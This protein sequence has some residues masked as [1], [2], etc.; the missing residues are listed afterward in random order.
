LRLLVVNH[1]PVF[2]PNNGGKLRIVSLVE[3][4]SR[5]FDV[6]LLCPLG[7]REVLR[8]DSATRTTQLTG[9]G[10][11]L[12]V[13]ESPFKPALLGPLYL[14]GYN[15]VDALSSNRVSDFS[16]FASRVRRELVGSTVVL[17]E[18]PF[19]SRLIRRSLTPR[20]RKKVIYDAIDVEF[21]SASF[22][23]PRNPVG[24]MLLSRVAALERTAC[25][26]SD[27][28]F[29]TTD[30]DKAL[31]ERLYGLA[32]R[33]V[34]TIPIGLDTSAIVPPT[35]ESKARAKAEFGIPPDSIL[36]TYIASAALHNTKVLA[37][38]SRLAS[39]FAESRNVVFYVGGSVA[40]HITG[41][42]PQ[43]VVRGSSFTFGDSRVYNTLQATD[44]AISLDL[45]HKTGTPV[46]T[47]EYMAHGLPVMVTQDEARRVGL[48]DRVNASVASVDA[49]NEKLRE[50]L[51]NPDLRRRLGKAAREFVVRNHDSAKSA[52]KALTAI[53]GMLA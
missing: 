44:V 8:S 7:T 35:E 12:D 47:L 19:L 33:R 16:A 21:A 31:L 25:S 11:E 1:F 37:L 2:P 45:N 41:A 29:A 48:T 52:D 14:L 40:S 15:S 32:E 4:F 46:K 18:H 24:N 20:D 3:H 42:V 43:N 23:N 26:M 49:M 53:Q 39:E 5:F 50:L 10:K 22:Q 36:V 13:A 27:A 28:V 9:G 34:V 38:I 30:Y 6:T 17:M 51:E